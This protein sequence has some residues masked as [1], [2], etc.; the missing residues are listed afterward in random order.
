MKETIPQV[1]EVIFSNSPVQERD[2]YKLLQQKV[3]RRKFEN[4]V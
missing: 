4:L 3:A 2:K 1:L